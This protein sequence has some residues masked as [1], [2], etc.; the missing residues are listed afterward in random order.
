ML[1]KQAYFDFH[2]LYKGKLQF[3]LM[4]E[5]GE[6]L[7]VVMFLCLFKS[8]VLQKL[9]FRS[10]WD[11]NPHSPGASWSWASYISSLKLGFVTRKVGVMLPTLQGW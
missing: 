8:Y 3:I 5:Y 11:S 10:T 2:K 1:R 7:I 6:F 9:M 4:A